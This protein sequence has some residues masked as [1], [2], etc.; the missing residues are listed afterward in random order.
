MTPRRPAL[1]LLTVLV[2]A[3]GLRLWGITHGLPHSYYGDESHFLQRSLAFGSGDLNPHWFH[4]PALYMYAVFAA[5]G[6]VY[7]VGLL[8]GLWHSVDDF[9]IA[10]ILDPGALYLAGRLL[11]VIFGVCGVW[12]AYRVGARFFGRRQGLFAALMLALALGHVEASQVIKADVPAAC[13]AI[14]SMYFLLGYLESRRIR[15]MAL[16]GALAGLGAATKYYTILMLLPVAA[17]ALLVARGAPRPRWRTGVAALGT[18]TA[19][20]FGA[21]FAGSPCNF[22]DPLG[23]HWTLAPLRQATTAFRKLS[24][25]AVEAR[26]LDF[27]VER[28]GTL[29]ATIDYVRVLASRPGLGTVIA[30]LCAAGMVTM[31]ARPRPRAL[32]L[33]LFPVLLAAASILSFP[34]YADPRHQLPLYPFLAV[35]AGCFLAVATARAGRWRW[36]VC[37]GLGVALV[38]QPLA[39]IIDTN[40]RQ[41]REETRNVARTWIEQHIPAGTRLLVDE[42]GPPLLKDAAWIDAILQLEVAPD[43]GG[44]FTTHYTTYLD[45]Q[46]RAA[47]RAVAYDAHE[48]RAPWW[49]EH[50]TENG[51]RVLASDFDRDM[52]NPYKPVGVFDYDHY[53]RDG[54]AFA[55]VHSDNYG[56]FFIPNRTHLTLPAFR[57]FYHELFERGELVKEFAPDGR[58]LTGPVVRIYRLGVA[59]P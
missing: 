27:I 58:G 50:F 52:G 41:M 33:L 43:A 55:I 45:Y 59:G 46:R 21:Y 20:L 14:W 54:F 38:A 16:A 17:A 15:D 53:Q 4:K 42:N 47:E 48:I 11:T 39:A 3:A 6:L 2:L 24:G 57:R 19:A 40:R 28:A 13:F 51:T 18:G 56:R 26:P 8:A 49:R 32:L 1:L 7:V 25:A 36:L 5:C 30:L 10:Y 23:R 29:E 12:G 44:Q 22:L 31:L 35:G 34:G 9:A 37:A